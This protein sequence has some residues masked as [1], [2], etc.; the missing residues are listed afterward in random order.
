MYTIML[1]T[2]EVEQPMLNLVTGEV[3]EFANADEAMPHLEA[4]RD[5][6]SHA[7]LVPV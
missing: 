4:A 2:G 6:H 7:Y 1:V 3:A 5:I